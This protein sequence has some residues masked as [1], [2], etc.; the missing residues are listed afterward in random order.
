ML[1]DG[2]TPQLLRCFSEESILCAMDGMV[3]NARG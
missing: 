3:N 2:S 1:Y